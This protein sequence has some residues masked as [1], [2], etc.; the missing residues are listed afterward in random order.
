MPGITNNNEVFI[1]RQFIS[2]TWNV[3]QTTIQDPY[4]IQL[5]TTFQTYVPAPVVTVSAPPAF[6]HL[7]PVNREASTLR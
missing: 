6:L 3:Q 5:Q 4:Q 2:Y 1:A 7:Q